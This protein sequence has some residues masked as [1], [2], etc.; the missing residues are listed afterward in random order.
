[1]TLYHVLPVAEGV[2]K[3]ID[4]YTV[5][6]LNIYS[7]GQKRFRVTISLIRRVFAN[8][9]GDR[10]LIPGRVI[11]KTQKMVLDAAL[12]NTQHYKVRIEGKWRN[13]GNGVAP[14]TT[15]RWSSYWKGSLRLQTLLYFRALSENQTRSNTYSVYSAYLS[16]TQEHRVGTPVENQLHYTN[17]LSIYGMICCILYV[18]IVSTCP[19]DS[20]MSTLENW[21]LS[22]IR[23]K[24]FRVSPCNISLDVSNWGAQSLRGL[25]D[26]NRS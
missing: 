15:L 12:L 24:S 14:S 26:E 25:S 18:M 3:Y 4:V 19:F 20:L 5:S 7:E 2:G 9:W 21:H 13:P 22:R 1:M 8:C 11:P 17:S 6:H 16:L 10:G 23:G